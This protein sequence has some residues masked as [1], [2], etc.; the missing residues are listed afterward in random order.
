MVA[1][2]SPVR[3]YLLK[4][5][6]L[7]KLD[8]KHKKDSK[9]FSCSSWSGQVRSGQNMLSKGRGRKLLDAKKCYQNKKAGW[10]PA[11]PA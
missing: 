7:E 4:T 2:D 5:G 11:T 10:E 8:I 1:C 3:T 9:N 6:V